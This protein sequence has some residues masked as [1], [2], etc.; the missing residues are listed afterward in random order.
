MKLSSYYVPV[1]KE[2]PSDCKIASH[3]LMLQ[4]GMIRQNAAG[5]YTFLPL[6]IKVIDKITNVIRQEINSMGGSQVIMPT[7]QEADL[8]I[9]SDRYDA[10]G[11]EML[12][13]TDRHGR[14]LLYSPTNE[15]ICSHLL[16]KDVSSYKDLPKNLYQ[17]N[18]KF[19]DE[20]RPRHGLM[21]AREFLMF[22]GYSF[23]TNQSQAEEVYYNYYKSFLTIFRKLGLFA[24]PVRAATGAIGGDLSHEFQIISND[25]GESKIFFDKEFE[26]LYK[27]KKPLDF[28]SINHLY[29][30]TDE[31]AVE[32]MDSNKPADAI[33]KMGIEVGHIFFFGDKYTKS[34][35]ISVRDNT[36]KELYP[37]M[38]SY[39]LG[40]TRILAAAIEA[41]HDS[42]GIIWN[43]EMAPFDCHLVNLSPKDEEITKLCNDLYN[44]SENLDILMDDT[45][46]SVGQK[47]A[48]ADLIGIPY[49][50]IV[51][52]KIVQQNCVQIKHRTTGLISEVNIDELKQ[53]I[54]TARKMSVFFQ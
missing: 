19:R 1:L 53:K 30:T 13:I 2:K 24:I 45:T 5:L 8:W 46:N 9:K 7:I 31:H 26:T 33:E 42:S 6:A 29:A 28:E 36:D 20:I 22:D 50:I 12:R 27:Q 34:L 25:S 47:L 3:G 32:D 21:R 44:S 35:D 16:S 38:G 15:E 54:T 51:G 48:T 41:S 49:Q 40:V 43:E 4:A 11:K 39:G 14:D 18:W 37:L 17:I 23:T 52:K 10:Y